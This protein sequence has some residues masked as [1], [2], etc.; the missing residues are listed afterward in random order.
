[1]KLVIK[2]LKQVPYDL[3]VESDQTTV[4]DLKKEM[5]QSHGFDHTS[6]KLVFN[7]SILDDTKT[8]ASY[9]IKES[10]IIVMMSSKAKPI[11]VQNEETKVEEKQQPNNIKAED[12]PKEKVVKDYSA[13]VKELIDMGFP[14]VESEAAIKASRG[15]ISIACEFLY[16]GIPDNL[17]VEGD[18]ALGE[19]ED[20]P[21]ALMKTI[22]S[23]VKVICLNNPSQL[24]NILLSLQQ[25][26]P[27]LFEVIRQNENEFKT[28]I[29]Q[30]LTEE[31]MTIFQQFTQEGQIG[32]GGSSQGGQTGIGS[33]AGRNDVI[34]LSKEDYE[35][36]NRLKE[37]GFSEMDAVQA[38]YACD[39][40]EDMAANLL[41][42]NKLKEQEHELYVDCN[43]FH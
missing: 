34:K 37:M 8:L 15:D 10:N 3:E 27:E 19:S 32:F 2:S 35:A 21:A 29:S 12:K 40:N 26:S 1:M 41:F 24:Q 5:E 17:P 43:I 6:M 13:Q 25:T 16:N 31:D 23:V 36:V 22:S 38:F 20:E 39:K 28:L 30:P 4:L 11:N 18:E 42:D 7:G 9:N 14:K 33:G